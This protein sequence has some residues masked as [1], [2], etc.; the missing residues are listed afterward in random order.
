M[1]KIIFR[2]IQLY[3]IIALLALLAA[4]AFTISYYWNSRLI[5]SLYGNSVYEAQFALEE[6]KQQKDV[7]KI[8][9][10]VESDNLKLASKHL[11]LLQKKVR[12]IE[13]LKKNAKAEKNIFKDLNEF[14]ESVNK[15][16]AYSDVS[17]SFKSIDSKVGRLLEMALQRRWETLGRM[18]ARLQARISIKR[19]YNYEQVNDF[20]NRFSQNIANIK[21]IIENSTLA[22]VD[23][24]RVIAQLEG[25]GVELVVVEKYAGDLLTFE[26][27]S[28]QVKALLD[29]WIKSAIADLTVERMSLNE[30]N[31]RLMIL[32]M[33][34]ASLTFFMIAI[35][36]LIYGR[37]MQSLKKH[38]EREALEIIRKGVVA[39]ELPDHTVVAFSKFKHSDE[40]MHELKRIHFY[41][42]KRMLL[43]S[44]FQQTLPF[45][46]AIFN[47]ELHLLWGNQLFC[48]LFQL[49]NFDS[50]DESMQWSSLMR[51]LDFS[52]EGDPVN[53][54]ITSETSSERMVR[55]RIDQSDRT[56][57]S[58]VIYTMASSSNGQKRAVVY[59]YPLNKVE[60]A[61]MNQR[62]ML[63]SPV[64]KLLEV[65]KSE[66]LND[67]IQEELRKDF[68]STQTEEVMQS[69][70]S[71]YKQMLN[72]RALMQKN[73]VDL[74]QKLQQHKE[75]TLDLKQDNEEFRARQ[76]RTI[77]ALEKIK[78]HSISY[79]EKSIANATIIEEATT[80][81][82][83]FIENSH[84]V[85]KT[86]RNLLEKIAA[87]Q[88]VVAMVNRP[89]KEIRLYK[90]E[91]LHHD[92]KV[93]A[94]LDKL[95]TLLEQASSAQ[96]ERLLT[97][98]NRTSSDMKKL[99]DSI[100]NFDRVLS[101]LDVQISKA[102]MILSDEM[103]GIDTIREF[104]EEIILFKKR[105]EQIRNEY[106]LQS[107]KMQ[108]FEEQVI[109]S[110]EDFHQIHRDNLEQLKKISLNFGRVV[111]P[112]SLQ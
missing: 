82:L 4:I 8:V 35:G 43:S 19:V 5:D 20:Y 102:E 61:L 27:K 50:E 12:E 1:I 95:P 29:D 65:I 76:G 88:H 97:T 109:G 30:K 89:K 33:A 26:K 13:V 6:L 7:D 39:Q 107:E 96:D 10:F 28:V 110:F 79:I 51:F 3:Y 83:K 59:F 60:E 52:K 36:L 11:E 53:E 85:S 75:A 15:L 104:E 57:Q 91:L 32:M 37:S 72:E 68:S 34:L 73:I 101:L 38:F 44:L 84:T 25:L 41:V 54:A 2:S 14:N 90:E 78:E 81:Y 24:E 105:A 106:Y 49:K 100:K 18:S 66:S 21:G 40:F 31:E 70:I 23:K 87:V 77:V 45:A 71:N 94:L 56:N 17:Q 16:Q 62:M 46:T 112:L 42:Q 93:K 108:E 22:A 58:Y 99:Y 74:D 63:I 111:G 67:K 86:I 98:I 80:S 47:E 9:K 48:D 92:H 55:V 69:L 103:N 64:K